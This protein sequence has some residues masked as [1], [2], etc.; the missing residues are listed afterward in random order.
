MKVH[1]TIKL[2]LKITNH[3]QENIHCGQSHPEVFVLENVQFVLFKTS[4]NNL[5]VLIANADCSHEENLI[6]NINLSQEMNGVLPTTIEHVLVVAKIKIAER[7]ELCD[8]CG[9]P[10][11]DVN[12]S[13]CCLGCEKAEIRFNQL[14]N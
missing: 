11:L 2:T 6:V 7:N 9:E 1:N 12:S 4:H 14:D 3:L 5:Q 10:K 13:F 8:H